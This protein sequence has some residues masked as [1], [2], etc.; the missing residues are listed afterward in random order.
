MPLSFGKRHNKQGRQ[1]AQGQAPG[2]LRLHN[3]VGPTAAGPSPPGQSWCPLQAPE[4][5][6]PH[7]DAED[8]KGQAG[9]KA[10][11]R[12]LAP[13][14]RLLAHARKL[15]QQ[16]LVDHRVVDLLPAGKETNIQRAGSRLS[17]ARKC[18]LRRTNGWLPPPHA[19][20]QPRQ[21]SAASRMQAA[22]PCAGAPGELGVLGVGVVG[23]ELQQVIYILS[24]LQIVLQSVWEE[25]AA[26]NCRA[27]F[28]GSWPRRQ[29][30]PPATPR[31]TAALATASGI[32]CAATRP[33]PASN[34]RCPAAVPGAPA[35]PCW[36]AAAAP[37]P[38]GCGPAPKAP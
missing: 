36:C 35:W 23:D 34:M 4:S 18:R 8:D 7:Q 14:G 29:H 22:P 30:S 6:P 5:R 13:A 38:G 25:W 16:A 10:H 31:V 20:G 28:S 17:A 11:R 24:L 27:F 19:A 21:C 26:L 3:S 15:L 9:G 32:A 1:A 2:K 33:L 37:A 12:Q